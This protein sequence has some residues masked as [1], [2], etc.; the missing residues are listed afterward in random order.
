[1]FRNRGERG[2]IGLGAG[3]RNRGIRGNHECDDEGDKRGADEH[4]R[5]EDNAPDD[6]GEHRARESAIR[7]ASDDPRSLGARLTRFPDAVQRAAK[8]SGA[9]LIRDH[10]GL[11][12]C[13]DPGSATHHYAA[14]RAASCR[15]TFYL[16]C[17]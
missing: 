5:A 15:E 12:A 11:G 16:A 6:V 3:H 10:S 2:G 7:R 13:D 1:M 14:L 8:R 9:P 17:R 4:G